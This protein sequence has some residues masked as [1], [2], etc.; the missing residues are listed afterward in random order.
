M[1]PKL[2]YF[3]KVVLSKSDSLFSYG[4]TENIITKLNCLFCVF[5]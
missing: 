2:V 5:Y 1:I 3:N 4:M